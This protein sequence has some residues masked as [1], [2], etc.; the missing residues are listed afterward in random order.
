MK[1]S[2]PKMPVA[3]GIIMVV[4]LFI[5]VATISSRVTKKVAGPIVNRK[6]R[7]KRHNKAPSTLFRNQ[8]GTRKRSRPVSVCSKCRGTGAIQCSM[9]RGQGS[10]N[11][12]GARTTCNYCK[13]RR[14]IKCGSC[15]GRGRR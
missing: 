9:C 7:A 8:T 4:V 11:V 13:G 10:I 12:F 3:A 2:E 5:V 15:N 14:Q 1:E 6:V